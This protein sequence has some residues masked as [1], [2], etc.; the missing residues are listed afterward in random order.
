MPAILSFKNIENN[1]GVYRGKDIV[2]KFS[3]SLR[4]HAVEIINFG[5]KN[6]VVNK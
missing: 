3:E 5:G 1:Y 6:E 4:K 2:K